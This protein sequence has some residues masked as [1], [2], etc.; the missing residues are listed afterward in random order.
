[1]QFIAMLL[2][3]IVSTKAFAGSSI[4]F[5]LGNSTL[6]T[7][8]VFERFQSEYSYEKSSFNIFVSHAFKDES[9]IISASTE[10]TNIARKQYTVNNYTFPQIAN[11]GIRTVETEFL[12][13]FSS[14]RGWK[15]YAKFGYNTK[16]F[17]ENN[18]I[19]FALQ[20]PEY[21]TGLVLRTKGRKY[22]ANKTVKKVRNF[23][24]ELAG[25]TGEYFFSVESSITFGRGYNAQNI[26]FT[27][28]LPISS[29]LSLK[30]LAKSKNFTTET[31]A[32][33]QFMDES[34]IMGAVVL[35]SNKYHI[36]EF[37]ILH[38][39]NLEENGAY[40]GYYYYL[41]SMQTPVSKTLQAIEEKYSKS[42]PKKSKQWKKSNHLTP[43]M[44][45][46]I[47]EMIL[48]FS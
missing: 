6:K 3:V 11:Q 14:R 7:P 12:Y 5:S 35:R 9:F 16:G 39:F 43:E 31:N 34:K 20:N 1:M 19:E 33:Q 38:D 29:K 36:M 26:I 45:Q 30:W 32:P 47:Y 48:E 41:P 23:I 24:G 37:G 2:T 18:N 21:T 27:K 25:I 15:A 46:Q 22:Q 13:H 10:V 17:E 42:K 4:G 8:P 28:I 44:K 40:L